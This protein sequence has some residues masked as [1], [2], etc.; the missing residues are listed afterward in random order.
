MKDNLIKVDFVEKRRIEEKIKPS[1]WSRMVIS[2]K[3]LF[4]PNSTYYK[5]KDR[6]SNYRNIL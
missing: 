2:L 4:F 5:S 3:S 1:F 6:V